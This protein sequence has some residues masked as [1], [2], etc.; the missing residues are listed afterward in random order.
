[1]LCHVVHEKT[2]KTHVD[3]YCIH[4]NTKAYTFSSIH[5]GMYYIFLKCYS[6]SDNII[7]REDRYQ[8]YAKLHIRTFGYFWTVYR[9][10]DWS[11]QLRWGTLTADKDQLENYVWKWWTHC[12]STSSSVFMSSFC[13]RRTRSGP[14]DKVDYVH[15]WHGHI[16]TLT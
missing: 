13:I 15:F 7:S 14:W 10:S 12:V 1:M 4:S 8:L 9:H 6:T 3:I 16:D 11:R 2:V 5:T